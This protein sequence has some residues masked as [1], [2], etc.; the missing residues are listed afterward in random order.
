M[1]NANGQ[2]LS[3][4]QVAMMV[5]VL[6]AFLAGYFGMI[7]GLVDV[8]CPRLDRVFLTIVGMFLMAATFRLM[9]LERF[10]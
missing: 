8:N 2:S 9:K 3:Q 4:G 10:I 1:L 7:I 6:L 5:C